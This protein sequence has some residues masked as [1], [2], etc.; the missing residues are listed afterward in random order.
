[1]SRKFYC[2][3]LISALIP[4]TGEC[5]R[6]PAK[7]VGTSSFGVRAALPPLFCGQ[8][9]LAPR[10]WPYAYL[11]SKLAG[12]TLQKHMEQD[13]KVFIREAKA[14]GADDGTVLLLLAESGCPESDARR[15]L[16]QFHAD[17]LGITLPV[18]VPPTT[19]NPLDAFLYLFSGFTLL[20]W[21]S[22]ALY[23]GA[24]L[25]DRAFPQSTDRVWFGDIGEMLIMP[26]STIIITAPI[27]LALMVLLFRRLSEGITGP[28]SEP[29]QWV[30]SGTLLTG[31]GTVLTYIIIYVAQILGGEGT[32][33]GFAK[34]SFAV[35][36]VGGLIAFYVHWLRH[37]APGNVAK[38]NVS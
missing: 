38:R 6:K 21:V 25:I 18:Y 34:T 4:E 37:P 14:R 28:E 1:M 36:L 13:P 31:V 3:P 32:V 9:L 35:I 19:S 17:A 29:R 5:F 2:F 22:S 24:V 26:L 30:I 23:I 15:A 20:S 8:A 11:Q 7:G 27:Y 16:A 10:R 12:A 33:N